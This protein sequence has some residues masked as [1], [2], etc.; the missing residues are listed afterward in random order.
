MSILKMSLAG[1]AMLGRLVDQVQEIHLTVDDESRAYV[2]YLKEKYP[3]LSNADKNYPFGDL[4]SEFQ[5]SDV[6]VLNLETAITTESRRFPKMKAFNYRMHPQNIDILTNAQISYVSLANNHILDYGVKG[7]LD[8]IN[9]LSK[10]NI[11]FAGIYYNFWINKRCGKVKDRSC[12][13]YL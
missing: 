11:A 12:I 5:S 10:S 3:T 13:S 6:N 7:L 9:H 1:D 8:T 4:L 2:K